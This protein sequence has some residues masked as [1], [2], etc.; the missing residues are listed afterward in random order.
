MIERRKPIR[1][2][3][4]RREREDRMYARDRG[5]YLR[6]H[7]YC[8]IAIFLAGASEVTVIEGRGYYNGMRFPVSTQIHH[9]NKSSGP[10]KLDKRFWVAAASDRHRWVEDHKGDA[11]EL[12]LLLP[13]QADAEGRW[14]D[15]NQALTTEELLKKRA[16]EK[17]TL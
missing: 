14:G 3:S 6:E 5:E 7:P 17:E 12:G 15:G 2:K 4:P 1:R 8:Q 16:A 11:R 9:R 10:R 13:I